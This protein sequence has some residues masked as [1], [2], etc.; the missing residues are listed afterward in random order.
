MQNLGDVVMMSVRP[1]QMRM[2]WR[3]NPQPRHR[4]QGCR[5][6]IASDAVRAE[7]GDAGSP[8][9]SAESLAD[10]SKHV[11]AAVLA[12]DRAVHLVEV[13]LHPVAQPTVVIDF[14][15]RGAGYFERCAG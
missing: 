1:R 10:S 12:R 5:S 7:P 13:T 11:V 9:L 6:Q 2:S 15:E 3:C 4:P 8:P 14:P